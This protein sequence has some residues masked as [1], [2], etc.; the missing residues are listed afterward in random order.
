MYFIYDA[1]DAMV[2]TTII[3]LGYSSKKQLQTILNMKKGK[4]IP[5]KYSY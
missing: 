2:I 1:N 4:E 3:L 5:F